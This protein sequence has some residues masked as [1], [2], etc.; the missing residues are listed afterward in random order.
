[1]SPKLIHKKYERKDFAGF[2]RRAIALIIDTI[3]VS[4]IV[5]PFAVVFAFLSPKAIEVEVP[6]NL[7]VTANTIETYK[8][9]DVDVEIQ[10]HT[11]LNLFTNYYMV[12]SYKN[13]KGDKKTRWSLIDPNTKK[14]VERVNSGDIELFVIF[15][16]WILLESSVWQASV[17]KRLVGIKVVSNEGNRLTIWQ[18][19]VRNLLK[20]ISAVLL[21][22]GFMMA[23]WTD[24][25]QALHDKWNNVLVIKS[26]YQEKTKL[27]FEK[28]FLLIIFGLL[29]SI[30][31]F[32]AGF[33]LLTGLLG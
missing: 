1:M 25:K 19:I 10:E 8:Q 27:L 21:L 22:I 12:T 2:W 28:G 5:L 29:F 33:I 3:V 26:P 11:F 30:V 14:P 15:I 16:Y 20:I 18:S 32:I 13:D 31:I 9:N 4:F 7:F 17:G 24:R 23:G 6:F